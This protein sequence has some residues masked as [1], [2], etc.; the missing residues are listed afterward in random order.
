M[1]KLDINLLFTVINVLILFFVVKR[2]LFRPV[3]KILD[4]RQEEI[5]KQYSDAQ[6]A[7]E[8]VSEMKKKYEAS[9]AGIEE[10][11]QS[12]LSETDKKAASDYEKKLT[13]AKDE[14]DRILAGAKK[15]AAEEKEKRIREAREEIADL[16]VEAAAKISE[17]NSGEE[18]DRELYDKFIE[19]I[20]QQGI[21]ERSV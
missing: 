12:I 8:E 3:L 17:A 6:K 2:F 20:G 14:A 9:L 13:E 4:Q 19:Q 5:E 11:K 21:E 16:V 10:E 7:E 1:L 15:Q 18:S